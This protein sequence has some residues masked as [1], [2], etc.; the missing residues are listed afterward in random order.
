M[1]L[2][3]STRRACRIAF[4]GLAALC[5]SSVASADFLVSGSVTTDTQLT[6]CAFFI[7]PRVSWAVDIEK[8]TPMEF[9]PGTSP[10]TAYDDAGVG[11]DMFRD[12][13]GFVGTY[14]DDEG[15]T[16][17]VLAASPEAA[18][19]MLGSSKTWDDLFPYFTESEL[20]SNLD[21]VYTYAFGSDEYRTAYSRL[22]DF[23]NSY[24]GV[25][26]EDGDDYARLVPR[27]GDNAAL[28]A[29]SSPM[30]VGSMTANP[31]PE[32]AALSALA[33]ALVG[34][35]RVRRRR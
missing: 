33:V 10:F 28:L 23:A 5:V 20:V 2:T 21:A 19:F 18:D 16:G 27:Y 26:F 9:A 4:A 11:P 15:S 1:K 7:Y 25:Y 31:V 29:F 12:T 3:S 24:H 8:P 6:R 13:W 22:C 34:F 35:I 30:V 14:T 32:P 17:V